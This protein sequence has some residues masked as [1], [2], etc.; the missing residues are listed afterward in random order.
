VGRGPLPGAA[1]VGFGGGR[2]NA[3]RIHRLD[4]DGRIDLHSVEADVLLGMGEEFWGEGRYVK[5]LYYAGGRFTRLLVNGEPVAEAPVLPV[6]M[7]MATAIWRATVSVKYG[8][9]IGFEL[10]KVDDESALFVVGV[11]V[12]TS[13][14]VLASHPMVWRATW[15]DFD[16]AWYRTFDSADGPMPRIGNGEQDNPMDL[17]R[18]ELHMEFPGLSLAGLPTPSGRWGFKYGVR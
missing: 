3:L 9:V 18:K 15:G 17:Y 12:E 1:Y 10:G 16:D 11:D 5:L 4:V 7:P 2:E 13:R 14:V 8:D 6:W